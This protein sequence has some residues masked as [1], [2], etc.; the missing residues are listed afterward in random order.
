MARLCA[1]N[2][3]LEAERCLLIWS[4]RREDGSRIRN[5]IAAVRRGA[6][7]KR[8]RPFYRFNFHG[9]GG[10]G[11]ITIRAGKNES[12]EIRSAF[13]ST[14]SLR[15]SVGRQKG[16]A[17]GKLRRFS[18]IR[19]QLFQ[20]SSCAGLRTL[21]LL[22][23]HRA[24]VYFIKRQTNE[25]KKQKKKRKRVVSRLKVRWAVYLRVRR[26]TGL[27]RARNRRN[28]RGTAECPRSQDKYT[29][30]VIV[31]KVAKRE[32]RVN[33]TR[34]KSKDRCCEQEVRGQEVRRDTEEE[35]ALESFE[36]L[37]N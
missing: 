22:P 28:V 5:D 14:R 17:D 18:A 15:Q 12:A 7:E 27:A 4:K 29:T 37:A 33:R 25:K 11:R 24:S 9:V 20:A 21:P 31:G 13:R 26:A 10:S 36:I 16:A 1:S 3:D 23:V 30:G 35:N 6:A 19:I 32:E 8:A 34:L 2:N